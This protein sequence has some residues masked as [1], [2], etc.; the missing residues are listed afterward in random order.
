MLATAA[1]IE[2]VGRAELARER[3]L[4]RVGVDADDALGAGHHRALN[5]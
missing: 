2:A 1:G 4:L 5:D 3:E